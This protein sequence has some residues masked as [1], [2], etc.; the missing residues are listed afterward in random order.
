MAQASPAKQVSLIELVTLVGGQAL[1]LYK[2]PG[3]SFDSQVF[4]VLTLAGPSLSE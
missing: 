4:G 3:G 2:T 1:G